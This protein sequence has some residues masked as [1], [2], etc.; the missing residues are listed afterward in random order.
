MKNTIADSY[1][2]EIMRNSIDAL[3]KKVLLKSILIIAVVA[4]TAA[5]IMINKDMMSVLSNPE[6][7]KSYIEN[8]GA[9]EMLI[10]IA[11]QIIQIVIAIIPG[12]P[13]QLAGGYIFGTF[14]GFI[15]STIG[16]MAG[17]VSAFFI[18][19]KLG[20]PIVSLLVKKEKL[21]EYKKKIE[22]KKGNAILF[23]L[24]L[25]P[26]VPK[27]ALVYAVGLTPFKFKR[28]FLIYFIARIP[29]MLL[30]SY[31]GAQF[32]QLNAEQ[33]IISGGA[34]LAAALVAYVF[35]KKIYLLIEPEN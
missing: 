4:I 16:I 29:A 25:I 6:Q 19:R 7:I 32:G 26:G 33:I 31:M 9:Y 23:I 30:A 28:F 34:I 3:N 21:L 20:Y 11:F 10:F 22:S 2:V 35:R 18:A 14:Y 15:L 13:I 12:E 1:G 8:K 17:S 24:C 27:D 5:I